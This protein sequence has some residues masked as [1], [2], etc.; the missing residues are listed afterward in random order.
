MGQMGRRWLA[1][2]VIVLPFLAGCGAS[3]GEAARDSVGAWHSAIAPGATGTIDLDG[4][5]FQ[6]HV[7]AGYQPARKVPLVVLLHGHE[8]SAAQQERYFQLTPESNRRGFLYAMPDGT[9]DRDGKRFW[10]A[11]DACCDTYHS[12][13]DDSAYLSRVLDAVE[14]AYSVDTARVYLV[15]Y[16]NGGFMAY[17]MACEHSTRIAAIVSVAG[18]VANDTSV[19]KPQQPVSVLEVHGTADLSIKFGGGVY[20]GHQYPSVDKTLATWRH[21]NGCSVQAD[22]SVPPLDLEPRLPGA[23]TGVTI[24]SAGCRSGKRVELWYMKGGG[25]TPTL[26]E[27]FAPAV[28]DFLYGPAVPALAQSRGPG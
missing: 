18:A 27:N 4:R 26:S 11:T 21:I 6:L 24:Y 17:R 15:G 2:A 8:S 10:N 7:P 3:A 5:P 9:Q 20:D 14:S 19:C 13:V 12:G 16:S 28:I 23:E 1:A 22:S 25:H